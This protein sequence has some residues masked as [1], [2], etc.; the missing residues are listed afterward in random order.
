MDFNKFF[1]SFHYAL[2]GVKSAFGEQNMR[3]HLLGAIC[4]LITAFLTKLSTLEWCILVLVI[5]LV[6][7]AEMFNTAI[8]KVVDLASPEFHPLAK[9]A[10]DIAAGAVL[11]IACM[12]VIIGILIFIPKW[13]SLL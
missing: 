3:V 6:F 5:A 8:E 2:Q 9:A 13:M 11:V 10:K 12:S 1:K 4:A 7:A